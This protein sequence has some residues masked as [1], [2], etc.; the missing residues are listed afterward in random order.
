MIHDAGTE[1]A[2]ATKSQ[3]RSL[4]RARIGSMSPADRSSADRRICGYLADLTEEL[5][6]VS[7]LAYLALPDEVKVDGFLSTMV[8]RGCRVLLP[9]VVGGDRLRYGGWRPTVKLSRDDAGVL[10]PEAA[11]PGD[12]PRGAGLLVVPG[13]AFD[14]TGGRLGR[15]RG[16]Y[17]R[18][19]MAGAGGRLVVGAAYECQVVEHVPREEHDRDV[20]CLVTE[21]GC[22]RLRD[23][24]AGTLA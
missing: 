1:V 24:P 15:G 4:V 9:R 23:G 11:S 5:G 19:L 22:R 20:D 18:L 3:L 8:E 6:V 17:D 16:Y 2:R 13:R 12:R 21:T 10:A 14:T 7:V